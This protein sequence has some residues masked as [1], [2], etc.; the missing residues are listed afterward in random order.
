MMD[1]KLRAIYLKRAERALGKLKPSDAIQQGKAIVGPY[2][3]PPNEQGE[4]ADEAL[5]ALRNGDIPT[6]R[7][8]A[9]LE[10][11][12]R[13]M[14]P[15]P[16]VKNGELPALSANTEPTFPEWAN[17]RTH[18][19]PFLRSI[20]RI[21]MRPNQKLGTGFL[22]GDDLLITNRHVF[23]L[24][25]LGTMVLDKEATVVRFGQEYQVVPDEQELPILE[26]VGQHQSLDMVLLK[27]EKRNF[28]DGRKPVEIE[29]E[30]VEDGEPVVAVGYPSS[31]SRNPHLLNLLFGGTFDVKRAAPGQLIAHAPQ[32]ILHD[33]STV[34]GNSGSPIFSMK[35]AKVVGLH[36]DGFFLHHNEAIDS[37]SLQAFVSQHV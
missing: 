31:D 7:Q 35:T 6:A 5:E 20:G 15:V 4:L 13:F 24:M 30:Q 14:R 32:T 22:V 18:V 9:A 12:V 2:N 29:A 33:C 17:F 36:R 26:L 21:D 10:Y 37:I 34:G 8:L 23:K 1:E 27:V 3:M 19:K 25:T 16:F 11:V 28:A